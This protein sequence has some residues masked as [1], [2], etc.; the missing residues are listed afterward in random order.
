MADRTPRSLHRLSPFQ[1]ILAG[2]TLAL[3]LAVVVMAVVSL[4]NTRAARAA[5][6]SGYVLTDLANVEQAIYRLHLTTDQAL[7]DHRWLDIEA[8]ELQLAVLDNQIR[9]SATGA[10]ANREVATGLG[11]LR[12]E[13][14]GFRLEMADLQRE[15]TPGQLAAARA[16]LETML[17]R[18]EATA[19]RLYDHQEAG[20]FGKLNQAL[21]SLATSQAGILILSAMLIGFGALLAVSLS[22]S[23]GQ[24]FD[25]AYRMLESLYQA[26]EDLHRGVRIEQVLQA[27]VDVTVDQFGADKSILA[28]REPERDTLVVRAARGYEDAML[29]EAVVV[30]D[31]PLAEAARSRHMIAISDTT[32]EPGDAQS[33]LVGEDIRAGIHVPIMLGEEAYGV[34]SVCYTQPHA[35]DDDDR[36]LIEALARRAASA[37]Q[38]V[39]L[40]EHGQEVAAV[41]ERQRLARELHDAVTQTLFSASLIAEA[42]PRIWERLPE[43]AGQR[44]QEL[45]QLTRG[46]LAEMRTLLVE[47]RPAALME[48]PLSELLPQLV[49]ATMG[50]SRIPISLLMEGD[51]CLDPAEK[52]AFYRIAQ[53]ALNNMA[54]H[55]RANKA[56]VR[57]TC[58]DDEVMLMVSDD[59]CGFQIGAALPNHLGMSIMQERADAIGA[60]LQVESVPEQGTQVRV[61][62]TRLETEENGCQKVKSSA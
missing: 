35:F 10:A 21:S 5:F 19:R 2:A 52:V 14:S 13:V 26:D 25:R 62:W 30:R 6:E 1:R 41:E 3:I 4:T 44:L 18:M 8:I 16:G 29:G 46:A 56:E 47:L 9:M 59:G 58:L 51:C 12:R 60:L 37:I 55:S 36:R 20:Y 32:R 17:V 45:R 61:H 23:V 11:T 43:Q 27:L 57:L 38:S 48:T 22:R 39:R 49:E 31:G 28:V 7:E 40:Y 53:E 24:E 33:C 15:I 54:K 50:R 34:L 42:L